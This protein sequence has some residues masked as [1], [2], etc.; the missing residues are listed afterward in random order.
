MREIKLYVEEVKTEDGKKFNAYHTFA[1]SGERVRV[2][3][4]KSVQKAPTENCI[5]KVEDNCVSADTSGRYPVLW[6]HE[7]AEVL[8]FDTVNEEQAEKAKKKVEELLD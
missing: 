2:K 3:M 5:I 4:R 7:I 6:V 1:K 8:A